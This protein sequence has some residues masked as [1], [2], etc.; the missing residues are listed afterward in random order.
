MQDIVQKVA[1]AYGVE[2]DDV[3]LEVTYE[4]SGSMDIEFTGDISE[5]ELRE[6]IQDEL[7]NLLGIHESNIEVTIENGTA[8]FTIKSESAEL[9]K[10]IQSALSSESSAATLAGAISTS[11]PSVT[12]S[13]IQVGDEVVLDV[14][15]T[16][17]TTS[18][19][20]NLEEAS[21]KVTVILE[22]Q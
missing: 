22:E 16:V 18:A 20:N 10:E 2:E 4:T 1:T 13:D 19:S 12:V 14:I 6:V 15:V 8:K 7:A 21:K 5:E 17:D 3:A 9:A 11:L